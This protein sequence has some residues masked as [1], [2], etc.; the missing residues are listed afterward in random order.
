[1]NKEE[2][3]SFVAKKMKL[4]RIENS[5]T[6][7]KMAD[8]LGISKKTLVQIEKERVLPSWT[9]VIAICALFRESEVLQTLFGSDPLEVVETLARDHVEHTTTKTMGGK[10]WWKDIERQGRFRLQQNLISQH[11]RILDDEN[12]RWYST[13]NQEEGCRKLVLFSEQMG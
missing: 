3:I 7:E 8:I 5:Y 11:Y 1:M 10:V 9:T 13:F 6:Q 2:V 4:V 12:N